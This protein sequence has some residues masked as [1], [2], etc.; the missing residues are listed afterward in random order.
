MPVTR[1]KTVAGRDYD[2]P[3]AE[4]MGCWSTRFRLCTALRA[5]IGLVWGQRETE[6]C[7]PWVPQVGYTVL[8]VGKL[9]Y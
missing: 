9:I 5:R 7:L 6:V 4:G 2:N 1:L 3:A 8:T